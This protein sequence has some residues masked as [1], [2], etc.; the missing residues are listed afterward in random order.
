MEALR[1]GLTNVMPALALAAAAYAVTLA[2]DW[3]NIQRLGAAL[4]WGGEEVPY[5]GAIFW[6]V[7]GRRRHRSP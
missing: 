5:Y 7:M 3:L 1:K 2:T 6:G 4:V